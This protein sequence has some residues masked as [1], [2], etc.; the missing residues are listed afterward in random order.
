MDW[1]LNCSIL[2]SGLGLVSVVYLC[3]LTTVVYGLR[4]N[5]SVAAVICR[6]GINFKHIGEAEDICSD[7]ELKCCFEPWNA[8]GK[9]GQRKKDETPH[10]NLIQ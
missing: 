4:E 9:E 2:Q 5:V 6:F 1:S 8:K 10:N 7:C 3:F